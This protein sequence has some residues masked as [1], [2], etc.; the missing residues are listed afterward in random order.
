MKYFGTGPNIDD[1]RDYDLALSFGTVGTVPQFLSAYSTDAG[2]GFPDQ[3][4]EGEPNGCT[5]YT[6]S[7]LTNDLR[8]KLYAHPTDLERLTHANERG[9]YS[10]RES[11]NTARTLGWISTFYNIKAYA[12]L[13]AFDAIRLAMSS[14]IP[15][16]RSVSIGTPWFTAWYGPIPIL[17]MPELS[18]Y[19]GWHNWEICGW[20]TIGGEAMLRLK[21][22][23][24]NPPG[25]QFI[26][27]SVLNKVMTIQGTVAFTATDN[28]PDTIKTIP[29][30]S[31]QW[32]LSHLYTL[33]GLRY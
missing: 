10:I 26:S 7:S 31:W 16:K 32:F 18:A 33:L 29:V 2:F 8:E 20:E 25:Y 21:S 15:E 9:G 3:N 28:I 24:G 12:P 27:R 14:G 13:D 1:H 6:S 4:A 22:W 19:G 23:Q 17:P 5:N 30:T 11:L